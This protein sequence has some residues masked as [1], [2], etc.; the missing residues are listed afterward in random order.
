[1]KTAPDGAV[2][3]YMSKN[4]TITNTRCL[5]QACERLGIPFVI[6]DSHDNFVEVSLARPFFFTNTTT[7]FN[8]GSVGKICRDKEFS[9]RLL[10]GAVVMPKTKGYF[11]PL[12][13]SS[14]GLKYVS[15]PTIGEIVADIA[16]NFS[17]PVIIKR[18]AGSLG[19][20]VF[21]CQD[22]AEIETALRTIYAKNNHYDYV[23]LAQAFV[24]SSVE[25]RVVIFG[26]ELVFAYEKSIEGAEFTGNLSP[27]HYDKARAIPVKDE[28]TLSELNAFIKPLFGRFPVEYA[29]L[30]IVRGHDGQLCLIEV[31]GHPGFSRF[32]QDNGD[33]EVVRLYEIMLKKLASR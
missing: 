1:M 12:V 20:N 10:K 28:R 25:Y 31:N 19:N 18:N 21:L 6:H 16:G 15:I 29:G 14:S 2:L 3:Y 23:A 33:E 22:R 13:E 8:A 24:P 30:D 26:G 7:P 17:L 32:V 5:V 27:L 4:T 9:Y 11:N